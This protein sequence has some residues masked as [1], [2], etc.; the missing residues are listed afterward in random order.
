MKIVGDYHTHT[1]YSHGEGTIE[2]SVIS[3]I[4]K[5]LKTLAISEHGP[6]HVVF[7]VNREKLKALK[8]EIIALRAKYPQIHIKFG[9]EANILNVAGDLDVDD[10][11][12]AELDFLM[13]G[14][15]FGSVPRARHI[16]GDLFFHLSNLTVKWLP[17]LK[18][19]C[20]R[21]NTRAVVNAIERYPLFAVTHP[22]AKGPIDIHQVARAAFLKG[23][24]LEINSH[25]GH[26]TV[27][28]I[29]LAKTHQV[30]FIINS[31]AHHPDH[32]GRCEAGVN[33][34]L[35]A[36]LTAEDVFNADI[37]D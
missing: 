16:I 8:A 33:R 17:F 34:A 1:L 24:L 10:D 32:I 29:I 18:K 6:G 25:H 7:G 22:G 11:L 19:G 26:L 13:A 35:A 37:N 20:I 31:D 14:Y 36:G 5:G 28:N 12:I 23:T 3:A 9:L 21:R 4:E 2:Q 15:H 27:E 30:K